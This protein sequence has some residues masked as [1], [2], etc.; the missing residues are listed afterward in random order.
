MVKSEEDIK[1]E[2]QKPI[3]DEFGEELIVHK[4]K[5]MM[6][7]MLPSIAKDGIL[8]KRPSEIIKD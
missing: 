5:N 8:G 3:I 4:T 6:N 2:E 1:S 7:N